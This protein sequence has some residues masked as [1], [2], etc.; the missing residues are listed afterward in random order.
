MPDPAPNT[1]DSGTSPTLAVTGLLMVA[2]PFL[3]QNPRFGVSGRK[4]PWDALP[5]SALIEQVTFVL[6]LVTG[7]TALAFAFLN[8]RRLRA[9]L[10]IALG[11][12]VVTTSAGIRAAFPADRF[13]LSELLAFILIGAGL[14]LGASEGPRRTAAMLCLVGGLLFFW[15]MGISNDATFLQSRL[16]LL[17]EEV[18]AVLK[19]ETVRPGVPNYVEWTLVPY[20]L[21]ALS[22]LGAVVYS[23]WRSVWLARI[24]WF[25]LALAIAYPIRVALEKTLAINTESVARALYQ[26]L[27]VYGLVV[28]MLGMYVIADV[29]REQEAA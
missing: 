23:M 10:L 1:S 18:G 29:G 24:A 28:W 21:F 6:W 27:G 12:A 4:W 19:G 3:A 5:Q 26:G 11:A 16:A 2:M 15:I 7:V 20:A 22:A 9:T 25:L 17:V 8:E 14:W 13:N